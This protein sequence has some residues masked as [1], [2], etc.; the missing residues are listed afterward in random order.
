MNKDKY[1]STEEALEAELL[2]KKR[3]M[4]CNRTFSQIQLCGRCRMVTYCSKE[5][6]RADWTKRHRR[7]CPQLVATANAIKASE[8]SDRK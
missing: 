4:N 6:Q 5:C 3:C 1:A 7:L 2:E 8:T